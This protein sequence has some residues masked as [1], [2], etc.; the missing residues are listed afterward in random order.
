MTAPANKSVTN[1]SNGLQFGLDKSERITGFQ[2]VNLVE[3][4]ST[5]RVLTVPNVASGGVL[6]A[7]VT[8]AHTH[9]I[10]IESENG[11]AYYILCT[12]TVTNRTGG[13]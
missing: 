13:A 11:T 1:F 3:I 12:T 9:S 5:A 4:P 8:D 2:G 6:A 7:H 10:R